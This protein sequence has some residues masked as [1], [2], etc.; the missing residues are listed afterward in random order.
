ME[1]DDFR[2][3]ELIKQPELVEARASEWKTALLETAWSE[4]VELLGLQ[5]GDI[6]W[7]GAS[8]VRAEPRPGRAH[9]AEVPPMTTH[10][11]VA[12]QLRAASAHGDDTRARVA[13][14]GPDDAGVGVPVDRGHG[15]RGA[16]RPHVFKRMLEKAELQR[17]CPH[18]DCGTR[19]RRSCSRSASR[20]LREP[21][22]RTQGFRDHAAVYARW[23]P[24][25]SRRRGVDRLD[26]T[27]PSATPAQPDAAIADR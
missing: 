21:A 15:P 6:D 27:Q 16:E 23:L 25:G 4:D 13:E 26:E 19:S 9:H 10:R 2:R 8:S 18:P 14:E 24:D 1:A 20:D 11:H 5:W 12:R 3:T 7:R 22:T 17:R